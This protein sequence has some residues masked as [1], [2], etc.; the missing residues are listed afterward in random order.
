MVSLKACRHFWPAF[1]CQSY[2]LSEVHIVSKKI[3]EYF[4]AREMHTEPESNENVELETSL[5]HLFALQGSQ[6]LNGA[7][8]VA[9]EN[10]TEGLLLDVRHLYHLV[11]DG[12]FLHVDV[13]GD[14]EQVI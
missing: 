14:L 9:D 6:A 2:Q 10:F 7:F 1:E 3:V 13:H 8:F 4:A 11:D 5:P 12:L